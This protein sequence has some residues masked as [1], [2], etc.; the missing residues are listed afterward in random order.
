M[1]CTIS[2]LLI[3]ILRRKRSDAFVQGCMKHEAGA[4]Y[5]TVSRNLLPYECRMD[6]FQ[7]PQLD[8]ERFKVRIENPPGKPS[9][10]PQ[11]QPLYAHAGQPPPLD[12]EHFCSGRHFSVN[13]R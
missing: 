6:C 8:S 9:P 13:Q 10:M 12:D 7:V 11:A 5:P 4:L 1:K 3:L 2:Q